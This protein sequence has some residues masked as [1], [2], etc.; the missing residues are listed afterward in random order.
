M[1]WVGDFGFLVPRTCPPD[2]G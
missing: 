2:R 1:M